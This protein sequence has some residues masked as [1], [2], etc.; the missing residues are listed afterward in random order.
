[1]QEI[2]VIPIQFTGRNKYGDFNWMITE[3][4]YANSLFIFN[5]NEEYHNKCISGSGNAIIRKYNKYN[6]NLNFPQSA[7]IPT[8][9]FKNGGYIKLNKH[10]KKVIDDSIDEIIELINIYKYDKIYFSSDSEGK[11]GT[12]IFSVGDDVIEYITY[13]IKS[14]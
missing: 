5:D 14:L 4:E 1:M 2:Q 11:L 6:K 13:R 9:T 8:G 10:V 7:G 12:S 3:P